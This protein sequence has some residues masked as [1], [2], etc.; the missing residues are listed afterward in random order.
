MS[1]KEKQ[2]T[3]ATFPQTSIKNVMSVPIKQKDQRTT[4]RNQKKRRKI[5]KKFEDDPNPRAEHIT[6]KVQ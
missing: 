2:Q 5:I 6:N 4:P 3:Q 1:L